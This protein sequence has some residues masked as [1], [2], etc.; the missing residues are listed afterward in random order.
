MQQTHAVFGE[1]AHHGSESFN[2]EHVV[3][4]SA[5]EEYSHVMRAKSTFVG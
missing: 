4:N 1:L 2:Y 3:R 5:S